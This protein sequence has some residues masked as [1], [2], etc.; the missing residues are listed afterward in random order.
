VRFAQKR[1]RD[2]V[3]NPHHAPAPQNVVLRWHLCDPSL[4]DRDAERLSGH[5]QKRPPLRAAV[6]K[7]EGG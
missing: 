4:T 7:R 5:V 6:R 2:I 1:V 3:N